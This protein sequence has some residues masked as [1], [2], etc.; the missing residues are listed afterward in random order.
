MPW[1]E[2]RHCGGV[3]KSADH[4]TKNKVED[5][6]KLERSVQQNTIVP[7]AVNSVCKIKADILSGRLTTLETCKE[8]VAA[9]WHTSWRVMPMH[10]NPQMVLRPLRFISQN[11][12]YLWDI[13]Q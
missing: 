12:V 7:R 4:G 10:A 5:N 1:H 3:S 9:G 6:L 2:F 13:T 8:M 11:G